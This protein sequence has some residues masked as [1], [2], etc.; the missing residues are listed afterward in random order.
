MESYNPAKTA[1]KILSVNAK[2]MNG[3]IF[4]HPLEILREV[5][6]T[7]TIHHK[8]TKDFLP[9]MASLLLKFALVLT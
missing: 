7:D 5:V 4:T 1:Q 6:D 3:G 8:I 2:S 9:L